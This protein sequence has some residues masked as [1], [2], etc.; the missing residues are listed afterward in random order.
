MGNLLVIL[1]LVL[2]FESS[3]GQEKP[4]MSKVE[5]GIQVKKTE[6]QTLVAL[7]HYGPYDQVGKTM[8]SLLAWFEQNKFS[9]TGAPSAAYFMD[10]T[11]YSPEECLSEVR[12][13]IPEAQKEVVRKKLK[14]GG[15]RIFTTTPV[16]VAYTTHKGPYNEVMPVYQSLLRWIQENG[17]EFAGSPVEVYL[18]N[19]QKTKPMDLLTEIQIPVT[20]KQITTP[21]K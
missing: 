7:I 3:L 19:P 14:E 16:K 12:I 11:L 5:G 20:K 4:S 9:P 2:P 10:P 15:M 1:L 6:V 13:P 8:A 18:N 17:Y 21:G